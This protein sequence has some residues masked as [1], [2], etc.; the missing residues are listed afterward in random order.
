MEEKQ[1]GYK[2]IKSLAQGL[3]I[4]KCLTSYGPSSAVSVSKSVGVHR[5]TVKRALETMR[6][7]GYVWFED[8]T[9]KYHITDMVLTLIDSS[10]SANPVIR[11]FSQIEHDIAKDIPWPVDLTLFSEGYMVVKNSTHRL[12]PFS[13]HKR[14]IG[15]KLP[16]T[17]SAAGRA[18]L[19]FSST[20]VRRD[21]L[22]MICDISESEKAYIESPHFNQV[23]TATRKRGWASNDGE[24]R[25]DNRFSAVAVPIIVEN[26]AYGSLAAIFLRK[27]ISVDQA[28][29]EYLDKLK[30]LSA[31]ISRLSE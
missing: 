11:A 13:F 7:E 15:R 4:L 5:T 31:Q 8:E 24:I 14:I 6:E 28:A 27:S 2:P 25:E 17:K 3:S 23:L 22:A 12:S 10:R 21:I 1:T 18:Y 20:S 16:C 9:R 26:V 30:N 19:S 29:S